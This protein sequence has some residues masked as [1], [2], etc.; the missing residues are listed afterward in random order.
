MDIS[1]ESVAVTSTLLVRASFLQQRDN[2]YTLVT[3]DGGKTVKV[4]VVDRCTSCSE[5]SLD[6][7][8]FPLRFIATIALIP[9]KSL[10]SPSAFQVLAPLS[11]GRLHGVK[12]H[13]A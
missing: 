5:T 11:K 10:Q 12:W 2:T 4:K 7:V 9:L 1:L 6:F 3:T 13:W 8:R